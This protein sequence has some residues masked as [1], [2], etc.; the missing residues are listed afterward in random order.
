MGYFLTSE[1]MFV[2]T[3]GDR[4]R[5]VETGG[6][7]GYCSAPFSTIWVP[8]GVSG[9]I[10]ANSAT[11]SWELLTVLNPHFVAEKQGLFG[12]HKSEDIQTFFYYIL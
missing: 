4:G 3:G 1:L 11:C 5:P 2:V 9:H 12:G 7:L 8:L 10:C 6:D